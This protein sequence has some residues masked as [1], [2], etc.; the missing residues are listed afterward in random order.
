MASRALRSSPTVEPATVKE[1]HPAPHLCESRV[2]GSVYVDNIII[3]G[4]DAPLAREAASALRAEAEH[5]GLPITWS[6][7]DVVA[8]LET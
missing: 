4:R 3:L 5:C 8:H 2:M 7:P 6:Y 1:H